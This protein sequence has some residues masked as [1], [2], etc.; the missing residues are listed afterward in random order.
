M[1]ARA[2]LHT[3][4]DDILENLSGDLDGEEKLRLSRYFSFPTDIAACGPLR[5][6]RREVR[7]GKTW[8]VGRWGGLYPDMNVVVC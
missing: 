7:W 4:F 1:D 2:Q 5:L 8:E 3:S 6:V